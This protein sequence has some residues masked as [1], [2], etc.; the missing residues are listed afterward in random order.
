MTAFAIVAL[1]AC[2]AIYRQSLSRAKAML[3]TGL[4][5]LGFVAWAYFATCVIG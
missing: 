5:A 2:Y 3:G 1:F 4:F